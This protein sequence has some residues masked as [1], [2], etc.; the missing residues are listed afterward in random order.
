MTELIN[1]A[2]V[3]EPRKTEKLFSLLGTDQISFCRTI[4]KLTALPE[5]KMTED[6][7]KK[8]CERWDCT[9]IKNFK[10]TPGGFSKSDA[11][12]IFLKRFL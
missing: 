5:I 7:I 8:Y 2:G 12:T 1:R 3:Y 9:I 6:E 4:E 11:E 10:F